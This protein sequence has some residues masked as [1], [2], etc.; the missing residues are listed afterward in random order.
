M[1]I[2]VMFVGDNVRYLEILL[3]L[4]IE[5]DNGNLRW[6]N[7]RVVYELIKFDNFI[8]LMCIVSMKWKL[9]FYVINIIFLVV[10]LGYLE[11]FVFVIFVDVGEKLFYV[12]V[13]FLFYSVFVSFVVDN[14]L[15]DF[16]NV[17]DL[18]Y[19]IIF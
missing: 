6:S 3:C 19:Y 15:E 2:L 14:I 12:V 5:F 13:L 11:V 10:F 16:D 18:I 7:F 9:L 8:D 17:F 1:F 4:N